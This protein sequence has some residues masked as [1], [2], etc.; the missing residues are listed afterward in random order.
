MRRTFTLL[1]C[2]AMLSGCTPQTNIGRLAAMPVYG[3]ENA[4]SFN[5]SFEKIWDA[6]VMSM[7]SGFFVVTH[8]DRQSGVIIAEFSVADP[9]E[10]IDCGKNTV[11]TS[12]FGIKDADLEYEVA[13]KYVKYPE[14][15][16]YGEGPTMIERR[17]SLAGKVNIFF[18][19]DGKSTTRVTVI[20]AYT[21]TV[22]KS[23]VRTE[24]VAL[25]ETKKPFFGST[26][27]LFT[28]GQAG[29][30]PSVRCSTKYTLETRILDGI[31]D[32]LQ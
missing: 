18:T 22:H 29:G 27:E 14:V 7:Q 26:T 9:Q 3:R 30:D 21:F 24:L 23:G 13:A 32:K 1:A 11:T 2:F 5:A 16:I 28:T 6:A 31:R 20:T 10:Y 17:T 8:M 12:G 25:H 4:A 19:E 15:L